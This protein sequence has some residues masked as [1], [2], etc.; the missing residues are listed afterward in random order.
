MWTPEQCH[1]LLI[2]LKYLQYIFYLCIHLLIMI[3]QCRH[4]GIVKDNLL[5]ASILF[6]NHL[7]PVLRYFHIFFP[8]RHNFVN[9]GRSQPQYLFLPIPPRMLPSDH[10]HR[11]HIRLPHILRLY[12]HLIGIHYPGRGHK[13]RHFFNGFFIFQ[14][15]LTQYEIR[16]IY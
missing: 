2:L 15:H 8:G 12:N 9:L 1:F 5:P 10:N 6:L 13:M 11:L 3:Q 16:N 7:N 4:A 14:I